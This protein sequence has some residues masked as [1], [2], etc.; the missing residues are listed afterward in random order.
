MNNI[1]TI[2]NTPVAGRRPSGGRQGELYFNFA[3]R[4]IGC[5]DGE[6][7]PVDA[8]STAQVGPTA[9]ADPVVGQMWFRTTDPSQMFV[10][11]SEDGGENEWLPVGA[12]GG[13]FLPTTGGTMTGPLVLDADNLQPLILRGRA[14]DNL[15]QIDFRTND[16]A[17]AEQWSLRAS[18]AGAP[19]FM[20]WRNNDAPR[21]T[22]FGAQDP[23]V[24]GRLQVFGPLFVAASTNDQP[25]IRIPQGAAPA[26]PA[27]GDIWTRSDGVFARING[28]TVNLMTGDAVRGEQ[29][30]NVAGLTQAVFQFPDM[31]NRIMFVMG[32]VTMDTPTT[33]LRFDF[34][35]AT[36]Q[37][38][39]FL[40]HVLGAVYNPTES[41]TGAAGAAV[42]LDGSGIS[43]SFTG[44]LNFERIP[45]GSNVQWI[46]SG[47]L[48]KGGNSINLTGGRCILN[49]TTMRS[50]RFRPGTGA[51]ATN[52]IVSR[53]S[54]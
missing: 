47:S 13:A 50:I 45:L 43:G 49:E 46:F 26:A 52:Q 1:V 28:A 44:I 23:S 4:K 34:I 5:I 14:S 2:K 18:P 21:M 22:L 15:S 29:A 9:P 8:V 17:S 54:V 53:W 32:N 31:A 39:V 37:V 27:N 48:R 24:S 7:L 42:D 16:G 38:N 25:G 36:G 12:S 10:W 35:S 33:G 30:I 41:I 11:A 51:F 3:D 40:R 20:Q 6:G 19:S